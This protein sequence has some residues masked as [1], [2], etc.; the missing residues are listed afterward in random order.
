MSDAVASE[1]NATLP[2]VSLSRWTMSYFA[3]GL[4]SFALAQGL[5]VAG[6]GYPHAP[7]EAPE[8]L[9]LVHL[10][11]LGWLSLL[12]CGALFQFVPVL[13]AKPLHDNAMPLP[14]LVCL[15][16][17]LLA[18]LL[19]FLQLGGQISLSLPFFPVAATLLVL[20]F[21]L[22]LWN[23]GRTLWA[24]RPL[25]L[26]AR[27]VVTGLFGIAGT[28]F[29]GAIFA[30]VLGGAT[31]HPHLIELTARGVPIHAIAGLG[32][33][34]TLTAMGVSYRLLA[35]FMLA[36][37]LDRLSSRLA[38]HLG[39][40]ALAVAFVGGV[41]AICFEWRLDFPLL[42][43]AL[44]GLG[45]LALYGKDMLFLYRARKRR[46]LELNSRMAAFALLSLV[47]AAALVVVTIARGDLSTH[48][49]AIVYLVAFGWLS[50]LGLAKLYKI[51]AFLTWLECYGPVLG[52]MPTPRVQDLVVEPRAVKWFGLYFLAVWAGTA[53]LL[54]DYPGVFRAA[55]ALSLIATVAIAMQLFRTRRLRDVE[56]ATAVAAGARRPRLLWSL[57][58][59]A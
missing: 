46:T 43:A 49:P 12:L 53:A 18:L 29:L 16:I 55:T 8:T 1:R 48:A 32:G 10:I 5:M 20:G 47:L 36:P 31:S 37:E 4:M 33:W 21:T 25:P 57:S 23:L 2:G 22:V 41:V 58:R 26:P 3:A 17:G 24:A 44:L 50:G 40:G 52:K 54:F 15:L 6:Y 27:F 45:A 13:V 14:T 35:M 51:V 56:H 30:L 34:L 38:F 28:V 9:A 39:S 7:V 59:Q 19:G 42:T 11:A